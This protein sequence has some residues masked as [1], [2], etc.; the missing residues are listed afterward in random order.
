MNRFAAY[1]IGAILAAGQAGAVTLEACERV[2]LI[3]HG[4][5]AGHRDFGGGRVG[6]AEWYFH[7]GAYVDLVVEDC[8]KGEFLRT[9]VR[10]ERIKPDR[11]FN[12]TDKVIAII[13]REMA[14]SPFLFSFR[15]LDQAIGRMGADTEVVSTHS[16]TC[17]CAALYPEHR[18]DKTPYEEAG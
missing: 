15:R 12:R 18:G 3:S 2:T 4:G 10:E 16:E 5:E 1:L 17:A 8:A 7:E 6:F 11:E 14:A 9:R 13:E